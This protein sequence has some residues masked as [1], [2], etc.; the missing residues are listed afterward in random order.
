MAAR[1]KTPYEAE[2]STRLTADALHVQAPDSPSVCEASWPDSVAPETRMHKQL[3]L[4][5][6]HRVCSITT[7]YPLHLHSTFKSN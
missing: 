1:L 2:L 4:E 5:A 7:V 6:R 3:S